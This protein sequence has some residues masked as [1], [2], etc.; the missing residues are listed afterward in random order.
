MTWLALLRSRA[1]QWAA[2][3]G[4]ALLALWRALSL[5]EKRGQQKEAAKAFKRRVEVAES[6]KEVRDDIQGMDD[7]RVGDELSK[8]MRDGANRD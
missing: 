3:I 7:A 4:A 5:A 8:W 6:A 1:V 2:L